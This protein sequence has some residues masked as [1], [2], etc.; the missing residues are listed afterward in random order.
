MKYRI[1]TVVLSGLAAGM[2]SST[3]V[4]Q[5]NDYDPGHPRVNEV[6]QRLNNQNN[7]IQNGVQDGQM[8]P[9]QAA[10]DE[11]RD[12]RVEHQEQRDEAK[13]GGHLT[14]KEQNHLNKELNHDSKDIQ[15][16]REEGAR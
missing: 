12:A 1:V 15:H 4:A 6:D 2:L 10:R 13:N 11:K 16:Q 8:R 3:A 14:K 7:R 5:V 9:G